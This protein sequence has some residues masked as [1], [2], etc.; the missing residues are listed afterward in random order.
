MLPQITNIHVHSHRYWETCL[1]GRLWRKIKRIPKCFKPQQHQLKSPIKLQNDLFKGWKRIFLPGE[2]VVALPKTSQIARPEMPSLRS[3][4]IPRLLLASQFFILGQHPS[5]RRTLNCCHITKALLFKA[6]L[7]EGQS[8]MASTQVE[9][10]KATQL[11][12][13]AVSV[14]PDRPLNLAFM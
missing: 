3:N 14:S 1:Y 6:W 8:L 7:A 10:S 12:F 13:L 5:N 9:V 2:I 11:K 4:P